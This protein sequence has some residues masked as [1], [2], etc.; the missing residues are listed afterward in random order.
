[1]LE[2]CLS[3]AVYMAGALLVVTFRTQELAPIEVMRWM[4]SL[5]FKESNYR[6]DP[7]SWAWNL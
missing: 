4:T 1:M 3:D 5:P 7:S 6:T 2:A